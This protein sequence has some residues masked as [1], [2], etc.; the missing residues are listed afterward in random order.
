MSDSRKPQGRRRPGKNTFITKSGSTIKLHRSLGER[1]K[2]RRDAKARRRAAYLS[3]LPKNRFKRILYRLHPKRQ[4]KYWFSRDGAIMALK[5]VGIGIVVCFILTVGVFAYFRKDLPNINDVTGSKIDASINYYDRTGTVLLW[6]DYDAVKRVPVS[7][8]N[9]SKFMKDATIAIEDKDFYKH[10]AFDIRGIIRAGMHDVFNLGSGS[11]QGGSTISQQVVKL[12][13]KWTAD[14]SLARKAKELILAVELEREYTKDD[15]LNGYLNVAPY[16]TIQYGVETASRDYFGKSAKDLTLDEAAML[17]AIPKAPSHYSP[18][19]PYYDPDDLVARQHYIIDQMQ[20]QGMIT[21]QVATDAKNVNTLASVHPLIPSK[22][23][24]IKAPYFVLAAKKEVEAKYGDKTVLRSGWNVTT[25]LDM[26]LQGIAEEQVSKG[27]K[28]VIRHN[29]DTAAFV[30]EDV[31]TGQMVAMVGGVDFSDPDHGQLN[32]AQTPLPPGSSFK[33][34]DYVTM[35]DNNTNVGAGSVL[36]DEAVKNEGIPGYVCTKEG[37]PPPKGQGNCLRDYDGRYPGPLTLRYALAGSRNVTAVKAMLS[38]VPNDPYPYTASIN[39]TIA[40]AEALGLKSGYNCYKDEA[41]TQKGPC[42][43]SSAIGD[44]AYMRLDEH[45]NGYASLSRG[46]EY[47]QQT[48][49][50]KIVDAKGKTI[51][52]WKQPK[53]T[54]VVRPDSAA[55][56]TSILSDPNASYMRRKI[57]RFQG[58]EFAV[59]T[60]TTNDNKDGLMMGYSAQYAAGVWVGYHSRKVAMR[61]FMED[62]TTPIWQG[63]MNAAHADLKPA[64]WVKPATLKSLPAFVVRGH[65]GAS[66]VEPSPANDLFPSWYQPPKQTNGAAEAI[67]VVSNK[68]ATTCTPE[69]AKKTDG[70]TGA[71]TFSVDKWHG[72]A[73]N[74]NGPADTTATDDVHNCNDT[75]PS[76]TLTAPSSCHDTS[77]CIFTVAVTQGT[78]LLSGGAYNVSPASTVQLVVAGQTVQTVAIPPEFGDQWN[79]SFSYAPASSG[80]LNIQTIVTDSV[81]YSSTSE[82]KTITFQ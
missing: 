75:L 69:I 49:I 33:P 48:Y 15:I 42:Y 2:A 56:I 76:V 7:G 13:Q 64:N 59:K 6:Q 9:I 23:Q 54:Q 11:V 60:G 50:L 58:W 14:R 57:H 10:G 51:D 12:N 1:L 46:G 19:G 3:T 27:I 47:I 65:V 16:G 78:H 55:I 70:T 35:I 32:Y 5:V 66:S 80:T 8:D 37:P 41:L 34:Y 61:D 36:Y 28:E 73:A 40:T 67:D 22:F 20:K 71:S 39:K 17:A 43:G 21:K 31:K 38:A 79:Y 29:G 72:A 26:R 62:M 82:A 81:L 18:Y 25:T 63:W 53:A 74:P 44:G 52:Q 68:L 30:A 4:F 24:G 77:D 45:V